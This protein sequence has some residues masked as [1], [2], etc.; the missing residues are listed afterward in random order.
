MNGV[1][2]AARVVLSLDGVLK[3]RRA[4]AGELMTVNNVII[5]DLQGID[6]NRLA[7]SLPCPARWRRLT[8]SRYPDQSNALSTESHLVPA[9][10]SRDN[11]G[12]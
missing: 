1:R 5:K 7:S 4:E 6:S 8:S 12:F 2:N 3:D 10:T 11:R 9:G